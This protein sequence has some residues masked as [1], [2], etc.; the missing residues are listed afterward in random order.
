MIQ[1]TNRADVD[2]VAAMCLHWAAD[3][4]KNIIPM[5]PHHFLIH[6]NREQDLQYALNEGLW[7]LFGQLLLLHRFKVGI[8]IHA[9]PFESFRIWLRMDGLPYLYQS[10]K[11]IHYF[12]TTTSMSM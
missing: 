5:P 10:K 6:L 7:P 8:N 11:D 1:L 3:P 9:R 4:P 2:H 12:F